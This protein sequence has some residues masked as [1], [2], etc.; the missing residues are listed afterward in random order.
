MPDD[1]PPWPRPH[2]APGGGDAHLHLA[3]FGRF[4]LSEPIDRLRYRS[5]GRPAGF[6]LLLYDR[7]RQPL[8]FHHYFHAPGWGPASADAPD[9][10]ALARSAPQLV[11][12]RGSVTDPPTLDYLR[13][14]VGLVAYLCDHGAAAVFDPE[15]L[16]LWAPAD[17]VT[18]V[19]GPGE[20]QPHRLAAITRTPEGHAGGRTDHFRTVGLR[21][22]GRPDLSVRG[23][24]PRYVDAVTDLF[25]KYIEYQALGGVIE[26][27]DVVT[28]D[29]LPA[30]GTC[31]PLP[32]PPDGGNSHVEIRWPGAGLA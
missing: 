4:D 22:F 25:N 1:L 18:Q 2:F 27:G 13:D 11:V 8:G 16:Q 7:E 14:A 12:Y 29:G 3:A 5:A 9:L 21:R 23:V 20:P 26:D 17:W 15:L 24:G 28:L 19:Y 30:D 31:H 32:A 10:A 6:E